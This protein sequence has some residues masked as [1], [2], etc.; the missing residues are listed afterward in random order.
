MNK[1][2]TENT[3]EL[4]KMFNFD[5]SKLLELINDKIKKRFRK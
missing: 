4:D 2:Q 5:L 1:T 3:R